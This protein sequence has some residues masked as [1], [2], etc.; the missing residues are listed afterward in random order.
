MSTIVACNYIVNNLDDP[1][2]W[3]HAC[4]QYASLFQCVLLMA[5]KNLAIV[6]H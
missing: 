5:M 4:E 1:N 2:V 6:Q 3:F